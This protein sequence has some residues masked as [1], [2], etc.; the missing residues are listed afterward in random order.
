[1]IERRPRLFTAVS[2]LGAALFV[3]AY[4]FTIARLLLAVAR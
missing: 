2:L 4:G 1:M 3:V